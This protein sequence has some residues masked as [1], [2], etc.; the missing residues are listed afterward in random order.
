MTPLDVASSI[1]C[2][3]VS[4]FPSHTHPEVLDDDCD[5]FAIE[6]I[7][8]EIEEDDEVGVISC[9]VCTFVQ[10]VNVILKRRMLYVKN[11]EYIIE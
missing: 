2:L 6:D 5:S 7:E 10:A 3:P 1:R 8:E 9:G 4:I 11:F